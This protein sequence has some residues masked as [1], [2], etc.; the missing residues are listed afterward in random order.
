MAQSASL[1][2]NVPC[3]VD[4]LAIT[5]QLGS[6]TSVYKP[7]LLPATL[8]PTV[9][10]MFPCLIFL[11]VGFSLLGTTNGAWV[12]IV[13]GLICLGAALILPVHQLLNAKLRVYVFKDEIGR[14]SCRERV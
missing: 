5:R 8:F 3:D 14:A 1:S 11:S 13:L 9:V 4:Q 2:L 7:R 6:L 10:C 12:A